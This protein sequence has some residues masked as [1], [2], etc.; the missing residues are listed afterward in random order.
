MAN[1]KI[2]FTGEFDVSGILNGLKQITAQMKNVSAD[3]SIFKNVDKDFEKISKLIIDIKTQL[4]QGFSDP[5]SVMALSK[6]MESLYSSLDHVETGLREISIDSG[7]KIKG[8]DEAEEKIDELRKNTDN[9]SKEAKSGLETAFKDMGFSSAEA[10]AMAKQ[11]KDAESLKKDEITYTITFT[12]EGKKRILEEIKTTIK[13]HTEDK[14]K[15]LIDKIL[16]DDVFVSCIRNGIEIYD[17]QILISA[18]S[19]ALFKGFWGE[20]ILEYILRKGVNGKDI[21]VIQIGNS[22]KYQIKKKK[23]NEEDEYLGQTSAD[24]VIEIENKRYRFQAKQYVQ[25]SFVDKKNKI[26]FGN[27][28]LG[29]YRGNKNANYFYTAE[30]FED[31]IEKLSVVYDNGIIGFLIEEL[32]IDPLLY[33][34]TF[35]M[36]AFRIDTFLPYQEKYVGGNDFFYLSGYFIPAV[37]LL[38]KYYQYWDQEKNK[39]SKEDLYVHTFQPVKK[40]KNSEGKIEEVKKNYIQVD[41]R[42]IPIYLYA[43][44]QLDKNAINLFNF[45]MKR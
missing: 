19:Y 22:K 21:E 40:E 4:A 30:Q 29:F 6:S 11:I 5:K 17:T 3:T 7:F 37:F 24:V 39:R 42:G 2:Q 14:N 34:S 18:N 9:F 16:K 23:N 31:I 10:K 38:V 27:K 41:N 20:S 35:A 8:V 26:N 15:D 32:Q 36:G 25:N 13:K 44:E 28:G 1:Q 43:Q 12:D 33:F 45:R